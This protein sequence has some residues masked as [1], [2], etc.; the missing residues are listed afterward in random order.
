MRKIAPLPRSPC[1]APFFCGPRAWQTTCR[2]SSQQQ[3]HSCPR[4]PRVDAILPRTGER[5]VACSARGSWKVTRVACLTCCG[6]IFFS[7]RSRG[8]DLLFHLKKR[9]NGPIVPR[10]GPA[11]KLI[12]LMQVHKPLITFQLNTQ[13]T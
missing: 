12:D 9:L 6:A 8:L 10:G 4:C 2:A 7:I 13:L 5:H 3:E 1:E 11:N